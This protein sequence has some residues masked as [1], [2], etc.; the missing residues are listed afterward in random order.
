M[1][2]LLTQSMEG[3]MLIAFHF[4]SR[5]PRMLAKEREGQATAQTTN[6]LNV[7]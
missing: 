7:K 6:G 4:D 2:S 1:Y 5:A 3:G